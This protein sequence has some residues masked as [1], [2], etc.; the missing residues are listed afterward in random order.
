MKFLLRSQVGHTFNRGTT[1]PT[2]VEDIHISA[3][4]VQSLDD[5]K[6]R[7]MTPKLSPPARDII[8]Y[9]NHIIMAS[10]DS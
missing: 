7:L 4:C 9:R 3:L 5:I 10:E 8:I 1:K 6:L 2:A